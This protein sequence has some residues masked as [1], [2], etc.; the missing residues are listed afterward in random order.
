MLY[1]QVLNLPLPGSG[2]GPGPLVDTTLSTGVASLLGHSLHP[3]PLPSLLVWLFRGS[4][5][6]FL[7]QRPEALVLWLIL[8]GESLWL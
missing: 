1:P 8:A 3:F 2:A 5:C 6:R 7:L 4:S